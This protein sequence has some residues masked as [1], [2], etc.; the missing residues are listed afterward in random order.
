MSSVT[1][2]LVD[3]GF[4]G[5]KRTCPFS[6]GI[7]CNK[8]VSVTVATFPLRISLDRVHGL[9]PAKKV[10]SA[11][12]MC[13]LTTE[14]SGRWHRVPGFRGLDDPHAEIADCPPTVPFQV[15][16]PAAGKEVGPV[17]FWLMMTI[18]VWPSFS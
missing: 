2:E 15:Q 17:A 5:L 3:V 14:T 1:P 4:K 7:P 11:V 9:A 12:S 18:I 8:E 16:D 10:R 13:D 6:V